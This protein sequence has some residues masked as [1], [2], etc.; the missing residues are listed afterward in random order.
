MRGSATK[1]Q[2]AFP[3]GTLLIGLRRTQ[4]EPHFPDDTVTRDYD[5]EWILRVRCSN[6]SRSSESA[7][8]RRKLTVCGGVAIRDLQKHAPNPSL[9][10][11]PV[12]HQRWLPHS[13]P[14]RR[15]LPI[16]L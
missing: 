5:R 14:R 8:S 12:K 4:S 1:S 16:Q 11:S 9:K 10:W 2:C 6:S 15:A 7:H 13:S 3:G